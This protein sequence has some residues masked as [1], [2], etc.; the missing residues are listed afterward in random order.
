MENHKFRRDS[1]PIDIYATIPRVSFELAIIG[2]GNMGEAIARGLL[3]ANVLRADQIVAA[4]PSEARRS[5][6]SMQ[7]GIQTVERPDDS[8]APLV[9]LAVKP[10]TMSDALRALV[11]TLP[12]NA[13]V[14]SIAAGI[15]TK[16]IEQGLAAKEARVVR[17][18][19]NTPML[20][21]L[22]AVGIAPGSRATRDDL[23]RAADLFKPSAVVVEI[24]E[25][26]IDA[27]TAL[28]G[29]GPAYFFFLV[30]QLI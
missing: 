24:T 13:L 1:V 26:K 18:M 3:R 22:G 30:E 20:I 21:G 9:I 12:A 8:V 15:T 16:T 5:L 14:V 6:F 19:P 23:K 25:D 10:Q 17:A 28:S 7:L 4:D 29:S 2:A 11:Q 27:V